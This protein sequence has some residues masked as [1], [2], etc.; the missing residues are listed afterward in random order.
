MSKDEKVGAVATT[1]QPSGADPGTE[2]NRVVEEKDARES[3]P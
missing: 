1:V 2:A 3:C